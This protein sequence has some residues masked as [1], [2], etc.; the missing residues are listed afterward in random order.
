[1]RTVTA[2]VAAIATA[3]LTTS[4]GAASTTTS[5]P[6]AA[7]IVRVIDGDTVIVR[8]EGRKETVRLIGI[9]TP[10]TKKPN[11]PVDCYGKEASAF[12]TSMLPVGTEVQIVRDVEARDVYDRLLA[13]VTRTSDGMFVNLELAKQGYATTLTYPPNVAHVDEFVAAV[14]QARQAKRGL[15]GACSGFGVPASSNN[16]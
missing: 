4:C 12:T 1:M 14:R 15:W 16:R 7:T 11:H 3:S 6:G 13:Y 2:L 5:A 10:E 8:I 9:D